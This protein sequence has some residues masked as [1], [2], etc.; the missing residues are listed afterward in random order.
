[1]G[2]TASAL[3]GAS[4]TSAD[5]TSLQ[6]TAATF[7]G[8]SQYA[9]DLQAEINQAVAVASIP[10]TEL[11]DNV[12]TLQGQ[13]SEIS[14]L[15][16]D[17]TAIQTAIQ[18]LGTSSGNGALT[19]TAS[20]SSVASVSVDSAAT[21]AAGT[22]TLN[23]INAGSATSAISTA[24]TTVTDPTSSSISSSGSFT[25]TVGSSTYTIS[26][27]ANTLDSLAEAINAAGAGVTATVVDVGSSSS[28][29]YRVAIESSS[30]GDE[31]IQLNDGTQ[32]LLSVLSA[33]AAA[34]YQVDGQPPDSSITSDSST[35]TIAP[36]VTAQITGTG[37]T[38]ITVAANASAASNALSAFVTAYNQA[39]TDLNNNHGTAGGALTGQSIVTELSES[40]QSLITYTGGSGSVQS[41][42]D[43]GLTFSSSGQLSFN[44]ATFQSVASTDPTDVENF[45][46]STTT[47]GFLEDATNLLNGLED[48]NT[49]IFTTSANAVDNQITSDNQQI[50]ETQSRITTM[51][52]N[53]TAQM[54][55]ADTLIASL[56]SQDTYYQELF[57]DTQDAIQNG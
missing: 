38:N 3:A 2:T 54:T 35:V 6:Q 1:M 48:P 33:G 8:T 15:Q 41:L 10:L 27:Q 42:A 31:S 37:E 51:Q 45:L 47:G 26:P 18:S 28:P 29:D 16:N 46:G 22:Y 20:D 5:S 39:L 12:T 25:L 17:F 19:A 40:L 57:T 53:L 14:T 24:G 4:T 13:A 21:I 52:N 30:L 36:G 32:N 49:G 11:Q 7:N 9:S 50:T 55:Q 23:V 56:E 43:L 44:S 34:Q